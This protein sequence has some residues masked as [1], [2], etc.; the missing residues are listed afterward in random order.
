MNKIRL[1]IIF[2]MIIVFSVSNI[3]CNSSKSEIPTNIEDVLAGITED[4]IQYEFPCDNLLAYKGVIL[5][6]DCVIYVFEVGSEAVKT[7]QSYE[8]TIRIWPECRYPGGTAAENWVLL[9]DIVDW[10]LIIHFDTD[11]MDWGKGFSLSN[12]IE[13]DGNTWINNVI[14]IDFSIYG[15]ENPLIMY[16]RNGDEYSQFYKDGEWS[17]V[18]VQ[19]MTVPESD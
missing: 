12:F 5:D 19:Y 15:L 1:A 6:K 11:D 8:D 14:R 2:V 13:A 18:D 10:Y 17:E 4:A 16:R 3:S 9:K 7:I